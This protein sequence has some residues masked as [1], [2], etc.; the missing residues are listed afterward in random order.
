[1]NVFY[2]DVGNDE[3]KDEEKS[4]DSAASQQKEEFALNDVAG[5]QHIKKVPDFDIILLGLSI[6]K[7]RH[8][9]FDCS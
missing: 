3:K 6:L 7:P 8:H 9:P 4:A 2:R 1:M 5:K